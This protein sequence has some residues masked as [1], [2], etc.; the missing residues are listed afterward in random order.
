MAM[1]GD[2]NPKNRLCLLSLDGGGVRGL[3]SLMIL[4]AVMERINQG[5]KDTTRLRPCQIMDV[6]KG[7]STGG[8]VHSCVVG[9][10]L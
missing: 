7:T 3:S 8:S 9:Y 6:I 4:R 1:L 2:Q 10:A 5:R